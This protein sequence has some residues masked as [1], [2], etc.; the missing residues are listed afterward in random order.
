M[1][2]ALAALA[3]S[4]KRTIL[5]VSGG[6]I[7][8]LLALLGTLAPP[9]LYAKQH[10]L[11]LALALVWLTSSRLSCD[12]RHTVLEGRLVGWES[13]GKSLLSSLETAHILLL[14]REG[15]GVEGNYVFTFVGMGMMMVGFDLGSLGALRL[16]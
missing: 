6:T 2:A 13:A 10:V 15:A 1:I 4:I 11:V 12:D 5:Q 16:A 9:I 8:T 3:A 14:Q 7:T